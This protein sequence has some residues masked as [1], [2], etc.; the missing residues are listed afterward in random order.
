MGACVCICAFAFATGCPCVDGPSWDDAAGV[1][2]FVGTKTSI[3]KDSAKPPSEDDEGGC[4][5]PS[6]TNYDPSA[7]FDDGSCDYE[8]PVHGGWGPWD[9]CSAECGGGMQMRACDNPAPAF[10]GS[11]CQGQ[12]MQVC[13][14]QACGGGPINGGWGAW[15]ECDAECGGSDARCRVRRSR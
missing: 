15:D 3:G 1:C 11:S 9:E 2:A 6:A 5:D 8:E 14:E 13:N 7:S 10:G 4:T 12:G